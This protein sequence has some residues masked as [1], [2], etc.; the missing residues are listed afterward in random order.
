MAARTKALSELT[1]QIDRLIIGC[2]CKPKKI[3]KPLEIKS[4]PNLIGLKTTVILFFPFREHF[5][6]YH[7]HACKEHRDIY[8]GHILY[9][10]NNREEFDGGLEKR[11]GKGGKEKKE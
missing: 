6:A 7:P 11:K 1:V 5:L 2:T 4:Q 3:L 9:I 10:L 8:S